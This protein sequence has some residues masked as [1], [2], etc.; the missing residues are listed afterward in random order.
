M[1]E[2]LKNR[3]VRFLEFQR[4][5]VVVLLVW[6]ILTVVFLNNQ[7][8]LSRIIRKAKAES[9]QEIQNKIRDKENEDITKKETMEAIIRLADFHDRIPGCERE[10][11]RRSA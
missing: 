6:S 7:Q 10:R 3:A 5:S 11:H 1:I 2:L 9:M 4:I 8:T